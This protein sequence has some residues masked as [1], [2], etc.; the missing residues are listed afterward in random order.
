MAYNN[1]KRSDDNKNCTEHRWPKSYDGAAMR[2]IGTVTH[3]QC[4]NCLALKITWTSDELVNGVW[5][6]VQDERIVEP[7]LTPSEDPK[8]F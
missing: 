1:L 8:K 2:S 7:H 3:A 5:I 6:K 4:N